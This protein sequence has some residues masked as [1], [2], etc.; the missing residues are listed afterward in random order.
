MSGADEFAGQARA[1]A[2]APAGAGNPLA[3]LGTGWRHRNLIRRLTWRQIEARYR[4]S[5][6]GL[7]WTVLHPLLLLGVY[8]FVFSVVFRAK[9]NLPEGDRSAFALFLFSGLI[10]YWVFADCV[11]QAPGLM[12]ANRIYIKQLVFPTQILPWVSLCVA[13]FNLLM[14]LGILALFYAT[15]HGLPPPTVLLLPF[16][17]LPVALLTLGSSWFLSSLGVFFEDVSQVVGVFVT[18]LLFLSPIFYST[19]RIPAEF[20]GYYFVNPFAHILEMVR[21]VI[22]RGAQPE[23]H[24]WG[25]LMLGTGLVAWLGY[26]WFEKTRTAFADVL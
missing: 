13:L 11:V 16:I 7:L 10:V 17:L 21:D 3:F 1:A 12:R 4:G 14:Q 25:L 2:P 26:A 5:V 19:E 9:W 23:W 24:A 20:R 22:F 15:I 8:T 6:L 18:A